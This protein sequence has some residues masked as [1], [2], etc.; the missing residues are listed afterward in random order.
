MNRL[1]LSLFVF[2]TLLLFSCGGTRLPEQQYNIGWANLLDNSSKSSSELNISELENLILTSLE[3]SG[4]FTIQRLNTE[5]NRIIPAQ[6][7]TTL[8][9]NYIIQCEILDK[10]WFVR[11]RTLFPFLLYRPVSGVEW[12]VKLSI[13]NVQ[14]RK[15]ELLNNLTGKFEKRVTWDVTSFDEHDPDLQISEVEKEKF[16]REALNKLNFKM[17]EIILKIVARE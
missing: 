12:I 15:Y 14:E 17:I 5:N 4:N 3:G 16:E 11:K 8:N 2:T 10:K 7:D 6:I 9:Y 1:W 13:L